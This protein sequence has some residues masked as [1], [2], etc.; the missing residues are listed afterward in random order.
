MQ[1]PLKQ[2]DMSF[3]NNSRA[4]EL[5]HHFLARGVLQDIGFLKVQP[6]QRR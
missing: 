5:V 2:F 6:G 3:F 4:V 1:P